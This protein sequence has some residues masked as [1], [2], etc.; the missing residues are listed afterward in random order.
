MWIWVVIPHHLET[1]SYYP[2]ISVTATLRGEIE[3][4]RQFLSNSGY[5][6]SE[7]EDEEEGEVVNTPAHDNHGCC[8]GLEG[9][10]RVNCA[11]VLDQLAEVTNDVADRQD[12]LERE[13]QNLPRFTKT[14]NGQVV[15][16]VAQTTFLATCVNG[17]A[18]TL[19][20]QQIKVDKFGTAAATARDISGQN[21]STLDTLE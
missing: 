13:V 7:S 17:I 11:H 2:T 1:A 21:S 6:S 14:L 5:L 20:V 16:L 12:S 18:G 8:P 3:Y 9:Q 4:L 15:P 10:T 19:V